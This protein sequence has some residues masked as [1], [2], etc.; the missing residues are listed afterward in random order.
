MIRPI[1]QEYPETILEII[2]IWAIHIFSKMLKVIVFIARKKKN[3]Q[4]VHEAGHMV[5]HLEEG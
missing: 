1:R 2:Y 3:A 4:V 5:Q